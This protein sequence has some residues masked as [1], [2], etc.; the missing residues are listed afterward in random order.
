MSGKQNVGKL[1]MGKKKL[2]EDYKFVFSERNFLPYTERPLQ[3]YWRSLKNVVFEPDYE[4]IDINACV[5]YIS[6]KG[7]LS[8]LFYEKK[9]K[10]V[11][12]LVT[13]IDIEGSMRIFRWLSNQLISIMSS[14]LLNEIYYCDNLPLP[15]LYKEKK[16]VN[17]IEWEKFYKSK[18][19]NKYVIIISDAGAVKGNYNSSRIGATKV[20][21]AQINQYAKN[22]VWL[23]PM[24]YYRWQTS[25]AV[26]ISKYVQMYDTTYSGILNSVNYLKKNI[27]VIPS[28]SNV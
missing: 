20:M 9:L 17:E 12:E 4:K 11:T 3:V 23:N 28:L 5:E 25:S 8:Q 14:E 26:E 13:I 2:N 22:V 21:L 15:Y 7:I 19:K 1:K 24:P 6:E 16:L 10:N 27:H 18:L